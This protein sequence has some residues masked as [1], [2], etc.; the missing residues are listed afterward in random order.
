MRSTPVL[1]PSKNLRPSL[2]DTVHD[3]VT[4]AVPTRYVHRDDEESKVFLSRSS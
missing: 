2:L 1:T 4:W 3:S